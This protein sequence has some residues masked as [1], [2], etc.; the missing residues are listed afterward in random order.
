LIGAESETCKRSSIVVAELYF[1]DPRRE[2]FYNCANLSTMKTAVRQFLSQ[3]NYIKK[4]DSAHTPP[5]SSKHIAA[6][7][8]WEIF[9]VTNHPRASNGG[10]TRRSSHR[11]I[12]HVPLTVAIQLADYPIVATSGIQ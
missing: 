10:L 2:R 8:S 1:I 7:Q 5:V 3:C 12:Y 6:Q 4:V 11:E 9:S